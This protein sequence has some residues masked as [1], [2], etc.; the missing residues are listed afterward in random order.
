MSQNPACSAKNTERAEAQRER[1]LA[2][3]QKCFIEHG[4]HAAS[5]AS[6]A[7][8]AQMSAGLIYRYFE[9]KNAIIMAIMQRQ[10]EEH[11]A[12]IVQ[13]QSESEIDA[14]FRQIFRNWQTGDSAAMNAPLFLETTAE[15]SRDQKLAAALGQADRLLREDFTA[16]LIRRGESMGVELDEN[17]ARWR[18]FGLQC[19]YEG[20]AV[21]ALREQDLGPELLETCLDNLLPLLLPFKKN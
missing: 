20:L 10:N 9:S 19:L 11:R 7:Q 14:K 6:I 12:N 17:E 21:R 4:F 18:A 2:A 16:W 5:M 15:A 3:A 13:L 1:I 8:E